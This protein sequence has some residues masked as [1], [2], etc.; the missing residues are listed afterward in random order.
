MVPG[1]ICMERSERSN[2]GHIR[3]TALNMQKSAEAIVLGKPGRAEPMQAGV[4]GERRMT[5]RKQKTPET[6][7][8][9][10]EIARNA[11]DMRERRVPS[12]RKTEKGQSERRN[13]WRGY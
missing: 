13:C 3:K 2:R 11:K 8:A 6:A 1:E 4:T 5:W 7:A 12:D 10:R 9:R